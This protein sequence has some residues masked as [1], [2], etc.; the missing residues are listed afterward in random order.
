MERG[1]IGELPEEVIEAAEFFP[2]LEVGLGVGDSGLDFEPVADDAGVGEELF[3]LLWGVTGNAFGVEVVERL[4]VAIAFL[5]DG[6]PAESGLGTV[7][8]DFFEE[9]GVV[10]FRD[11]PFFVV[12]LDIGWVG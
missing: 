4:P 9:F 10:M 5:E 6:E 1:A 12:V 3:D 7:E 2:E 11:A 8:D